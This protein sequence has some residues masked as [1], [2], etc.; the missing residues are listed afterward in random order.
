MHNTQ[1][2]AICNCLKNLLNDRSSLLLR[3][4]DFGDNLIEEFSTLA[5]L[6][7][8][9]VPLVVLEDLVKFQNIRMIELLQDIDFMLE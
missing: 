1:L 5:K 4:T 7:H 3:E 2:M 8:Q 6:S 9:V